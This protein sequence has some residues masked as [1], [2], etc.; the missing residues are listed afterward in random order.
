MS[1]WHFERENHVDVT[2]LIG[3]RKDASGIEVFE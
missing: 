1:L 3:Q 2:R